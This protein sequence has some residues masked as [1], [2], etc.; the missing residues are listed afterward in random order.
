[1]K[2][3]FVSSEVYPF[4]KTG[5][6]ADVAYALPKM[7]GKLGVDVRVIMPKYSCI[8]DEYKS[9]LIH[10]MDYEVSVGWRRQYCGLQYLRYN[11]IPMYFVDNEYYFKR[12][13]MYGFFDDGERFSFS[14]GQ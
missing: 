9:S 4:A 1:M 6:L 11:D 2:V 8:V 5:G 12:E 7:L 14:A 13:S 10:L 3:L